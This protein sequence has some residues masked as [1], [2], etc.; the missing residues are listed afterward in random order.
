VAVLANEP[1]AL[2]FIDRDHDYSTFML[3]DI[4]PH[5]LTSGAF[6]LIDSYSEHLSLED[7][8]RL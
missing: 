2:V 5:R 4:D 6:H 7:S 1:D 3:D 8:L